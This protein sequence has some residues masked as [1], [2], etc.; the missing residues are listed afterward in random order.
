[1]AQKFSKSQ[2][3]AK[4]RRIKDEKDVSFKTIRFNDDEDTFS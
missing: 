1:L 3:E 2:K 4:G